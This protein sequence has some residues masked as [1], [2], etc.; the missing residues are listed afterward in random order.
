MCGTEEAY[1]AGGYMRR[2]VLNQRMV[3]A[4]L[5]RTCWWLYA[6]RSTE[7]AHWQARARTSGAT[8]SAPSLTSR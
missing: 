8:P 2:A 1:G 5:Y 6:L 7:E 3:L 4:A